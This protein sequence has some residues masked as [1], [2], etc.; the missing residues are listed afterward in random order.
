MGIS[1]ALHQEE[2]LNVAVAEV[3]RLLGEARQEKRQDGRLMPALVASAGIMVV[4]LLL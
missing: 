2:Q 3:G 1:D 4:I